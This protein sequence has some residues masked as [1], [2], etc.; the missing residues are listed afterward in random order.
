MVDKKKILFVFQM[1]RPLSLDHGHRISGKKKTNNIFVLN[2]PLW[3]G[4]IWLLY[5]QLNFLLK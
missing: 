4:T 5:V 3:N 2:L 1:F